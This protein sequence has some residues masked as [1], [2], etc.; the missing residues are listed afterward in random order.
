MRTY[1]VII[2]TGNKTILKASTIEDAAL[3]I[4]EALNLNLVT[5]YMVANW[6][7]K[8]RV[9]SKKYDFIEINID[10]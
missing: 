10:S 5:K 7:N 4:N 9:K 8:K 2:S 6:V 1:S 3:K